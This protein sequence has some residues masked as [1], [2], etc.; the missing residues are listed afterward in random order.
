MVQADLSLPVP[1]EWQEVAT[2]EKLTIFPVKSCMGKVVDE[3]Q[4]SRADASH[5]RAPHGLALSLASRRQ[6]EK[7]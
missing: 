3:A 4:V 5:E 7:D 2:V 6:R 1:K